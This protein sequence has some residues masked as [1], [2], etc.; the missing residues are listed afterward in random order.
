MGRRQR[1]MNTLRTVILTTRP[2]SQIEEKDLKRIRSRLK[3]I[4]TKFSHKFHNKSIH[5]LLTK[6]R[7]IVLIRSVCMLFVSIESCGC[8]MH[9]TWTFIIKQLSRMLNN[10]ERGPLGHLTAVPQEMT[11]LHFKKVKCRCISE[12][13]IFYRDQLK[14]VNF[15]RRYNLRCL[16]EITYTA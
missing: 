14:C 10:L 11:G 13:G 6:P 1:V 8:E 2:G 9:C 7:P 3:S 12:F 4:K 5:F 16:P 15:R